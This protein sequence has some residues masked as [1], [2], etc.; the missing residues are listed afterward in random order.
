MYIHI[1]LNG[2][3]FST[4]M[5]TPSVEK[6]QPNEADRQTLQVVKV[7]CDK[8]SYLVTSKLELNRRSEFNFKGIQAN[9][10]NNYYYYYTLN[11]LTLF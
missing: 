1:I 4:T 7:I 11:F 3:I 8:V 2:V 9:Y 6:Q 5:S 10:S